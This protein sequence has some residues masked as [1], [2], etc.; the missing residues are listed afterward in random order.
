ML[1]PKNL[2]VAHVLV[3][4][5]H[6]TLE[7]AHEKFEQTHE[8]LEQ[9]QARLDAAT[10]EN[11][12]LRHRIDYL[13]RKLFGKSSEKVDANQLALA[14]EHLAAETQVGDAVVEPVEAD[15]GEPRSPKKKGHGRRS[16]PKSL[17]RVRRVYEIPAEERVCS[18]CSSAMT[19]F[20]EE[21]T[22]R[23]D[24]VPAQL[25]VVEYVRV[26]YS[27]PGCHNGVVVAK[28]PASL[29]DRCL[30]EP[31]MRAYVVV[32]KYADHLPLYRQERILAR[33][34][35]QISRNTMG[36]WIDRTADE[37]GPI[38]EAMR[39]R[40][41]KGPIIQTDDTPVRVLGGPE[42]SY[43]GHL[44]DYG[45]LQGEVV[46]DFT[47]GRG[48]EG[49]R[50]FLDGFAGYLQADAYAGYDV[51]YRTGAI[52]EIGCWAHARRKFFEAK[53]T[54]PARAEPIVALIAKLYVIE[55]EARESGLDAEGRK[56]LRKDKAVPILEGLRGLMDQAR[57][58]AL[59]KSPLG[60]ALT[61][62]K[63]QWAALTRYPEDGRLEIDNNASERSL[64]GVA[65]G[66][67][68]WLFA[69]S[70]A[71]GRRAATLYS[72]VESCRRLHIDPLKYLRDILERLPETKAADV[73]TLTPL[74][75]I[76]AFPD[77]AAQATIPAQL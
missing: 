68:N 74:G 61:Y 64:R 5:L 26:K 6:D 55:K 15:S 42:G 17:P 10:L 20:G 37:C 43:Q 76:A 65:V 1:L 67:K 45:G 13:C 46:F 63:N 29:Q 60:E 12:K 54:D 32:S 40:I 28:A 19:A 66:R 39:R 16:L 4:Q 23:L 73:D 9:T 69:G 72:L 47:V 27:C 34:G 11:D 36:D 57:L 3:Q 48:R 56:A 25:T 21:V 53:T 77:L 41:L 50:A 71:G 70:Q 33:S 44:W 30:A 38:V 2:A 18:G 59:P 14:F 35:L 62:T 7:A 31:G 8:K 51:L 24:Y 49:P 75:W 52:V 22:E 58:D